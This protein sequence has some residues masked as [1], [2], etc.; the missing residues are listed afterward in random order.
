MIRFIP[1]GLIRRLAGSG[2]GDD[3]DAT[4]LLILAQRAFCARAILLRAA[5][6]NFLFV[7]I[8]A[9]IGEADASVAPT[10]LKATSARSIAVFRRSSSVMI[11]L[12]LSVIG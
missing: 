6:L 1:S 8:G 10:S 7:P 5:A 12:R 4:S 3:G 11:P 9:S 2:V